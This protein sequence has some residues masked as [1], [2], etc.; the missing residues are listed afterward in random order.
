MPMSITGPDLFCSLGTPRSRRVAAH[1]GWVLG[2]LHRIRRVIM[3][4]RLPLT[5]AG[6]PSST[7]AGCVC[8]SMGKRRHS[9]PA[10][11]TLAAIWG[12][13]RGFTWVIRMRSMTAAR[14][15]WLPGPDPITPVR[16]PPRGARCR[17]RTLLRAF[18]R[19]RTSSPPAGHG[20]RH[21]RDRPATRW[22]SRR[23]ALPSRPRSPQGDP[24]GVLQN[25]R[26]VR[27]ATRD[28]AVS[29]SEG[30]ALDASAQR[31]P[32]GHATDMSH[33]DE[34]RRSREPVGAVSS[35]EGFESLHLR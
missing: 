21:A 22:C 3:P 16:A 8:V 18:A 35:I 7:P 11:L 17:G 30:V 12:S 19:S 15:G 20:L 5:S 26:L 23:G 28:G 14:A 1:Q 2:W 6:S 31:E 13:R 4:P 9:S 33:R 24:G 29:T 32:N 25:T 34:I 27:T 10:C